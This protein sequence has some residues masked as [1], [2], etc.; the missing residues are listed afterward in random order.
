MSFLQQRYLES[1]AQIQEE[2]ERRQEK[3]QTDPAKS[4]FVNKIQAR[5]A[6]NKDA[7]VIVEGEGGDGKSTLV[8]RAAEILNPKLYVDDIDKAVNEGVSFTAKEYMTGVRTLP[9]YSV[10]DY[11]EPGQ[12][13]YHR[14]FMSEASMILSKTM[15]GFRYKKFDTF[16][17]VPNIDLL[18]VDALR[19]C[20]FLV[21][22]SRQGKAEVFRIKVQKFGGHPWF[23]KII[24]KFSFKK[25]DIKLWRAYEKKKFAIQDLLYDKFG[26]QLDAMEAPQLTNPEILRQIQETPD[27][28]KKDGKFHH[29]KIQRGFGIGLNRSYLIKAMLD[30]DEADKK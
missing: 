3:R 23:K 5:H 1:Y 14:Q 25:P 4:I 21:Y 30:S 9:S 13:W 2:R 10:L 6:E 28:F 26:R 16:L 22:V 20:N 15:I 8:L 11:D 7:R 19:L 18:D 12:S 27:K 24:D 29:S 17:G